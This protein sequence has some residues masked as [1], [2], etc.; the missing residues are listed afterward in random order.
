MRSPCPRRW[1]LS[2]PWSGEAR[3]RARGQFTRV[4]GR[5]VPRS[6]HRGSV[7]G[8]MLQS[9]QPSLTRGGGRG[10]MPDDEHEKAGVVAP[11]PLIYLGFLAVG[12]LLN[13]RF[14]VGSLPRGIARGLGWA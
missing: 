10:R 9:R 7:G 13:R 2:T 1:R 3:R 8:I 6:S 4:R 11:P 14:P 12:L 5:G